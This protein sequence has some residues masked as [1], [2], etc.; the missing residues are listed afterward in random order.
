MGADEVMFGAQ[1]HAYWI[2]TVLEM[3]RMT[4]NNVAGLCGDTCSINSALSRLQKKPTIGCYSHK[5][6]LAVT[7][8]LAQYDWLLDSTAEYMTHLSNIKNGAILHK[9]T[10]RLPRRM[11]RNRWSAIYA[12]LERLLLLHPIVEDHKNEFSAELRA[13][14]DR[15]DTEIIK[16]LTTC[17]AHFEIVT[18][19]LQSRSCTLPH[20]RGYFK[21]LCD[22][23][24]TSDHIADKDQLKRFKAHLLEVECPDFESAII[25]VIMG[26]KHTLS[27][28]EAAT[29]KPFLKSSVAPG[30]LA[31]QG[32]SVED[33]TSSVDDE[34]DVKRTRSGASKY[35]NLEWIPASSCEIER[36]FS[37]A[38]L[39]LN[40]HRRRMLPCNME[41]VLFLKMNRHR[42]NAW[43]VQKV[44]TKFEKGHYKYA[45]NVLPYHM[46][47]QGGDPDDQVDVDDDVEEA[48]DANSVD[49]AGSGSGAVVDLV[50][51]DQD[52]S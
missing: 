40:D 27:T 33:I 5:L 39:V 34:M 46:R 10:T 36:L 45:E 7:V 19:K 32:S 26:D 48:D 30:T 23:Y 22:Q 8:F 44:M 35:V 4:W 31:A 52:D 43:S 14:H 24:G 49:G 37:Q 47:V 29:I 20:A 41:I 15:L 42:W 6:H 13:V 2:Q 51:D 3:Y 38:K 9:Y 1:A 12:T 25:K 18:K 16:S 21:K 28:A 17:L 50:V 11:Y